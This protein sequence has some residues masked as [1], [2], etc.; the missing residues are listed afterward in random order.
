MLRRIEQETVE[1]YGSTEKII[2]ATVDFVNDVNRLACAAEVKTTPKSSNAFPDIVDISESC[3]S[4]KSSIDQLCYDIT[5]FSG[6]SDEYLELVG[7]LR[8]YT[9]VY[10]TKMRSGE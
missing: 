4:L 1:K 3:N 8:N 9:K 5:V 2:K 6:S 10:L 7:K